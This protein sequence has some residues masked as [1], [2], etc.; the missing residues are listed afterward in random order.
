M[1]LRAGES[2]AP[3]K[4]AELGFKH[5]KARLRRVHKPSHQV[6][7]G[8]DCRKSHPTAQ[9]EL[10]RWVLLKKAPETNILSY[11]RHRMRIQEKETLLLLFFKLVWEKTKTNSRVKNKATK[12][13]MDCLNSRLEIVKETIRDL[14]REP[15]IRIEH[16]EIMKWK[17]QERL[18][19]TEDR[20]I[21]NLTSN[22]ILPR[23]NWENVQKTISKR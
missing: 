9:R 4:G 21:K 18:S 13:I 11:Q 6:Y 23:I 1:I 15:I 3:W 2:K 5:A 20:M 16:R 12:F 8:T 7:E 19:G 22:R 17:M 10:Q 14:K